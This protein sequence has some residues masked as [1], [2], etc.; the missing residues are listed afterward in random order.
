MIPRQ[1]RLFMYDLA[2]VPSTITGLRFPQPDRKSIVLMLYHDGHLS[3]SDRF[4]AQAWCN[5]LTRNG[6]VTQT[7]MDITN[8]Y[9]AY[10]APDA[11][12][13][14]ILEARRHKMQAR[15]KPFMRKASRPPRSRDV[16]LKR[17]MYICR[18]GMLYKKDRL[19]RGQGDG[20]IPF[21]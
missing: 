13:N 8:R 6:F 21:P 12:A 17:V 9:S 10:F 4:S 15:E 3:I 2:P 5:R 18:L 16:T 14:M 20:A 19:N 7:L 11:Y 1:L